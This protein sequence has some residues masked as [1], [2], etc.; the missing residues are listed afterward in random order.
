MDSAIVLIDIQNEYFK[1]GKRELC[2]PDE[3]AK[4]A[5][6]ALESFRGR[7]FPVFHVRHVNA[8]PGAGSFLPGSFGAEIHESVSP[9]AG[10]TVVEKHYPSAFLRTGLYDGLKSKGI[11]HIVVCGM[12]SHMCIDTSV[13]AAQDYGLSVTV[14]E[15]ACATRDLSWGG[16]TIPARTVHN[17]V[18]A[19]LNGTFARVVRTDEFLAGMDS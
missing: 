5:A 9:L 10:E 2:A 3:A 15:D 1:G 6:R 13:R 4:N 14:L 12:M 16:E 19:S 11:N 18:M 7:G 17:A 8:A